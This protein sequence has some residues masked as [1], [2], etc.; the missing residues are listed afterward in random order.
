M[1][2]E[3]KLKSLVNHYREVT[4]L[5]FKTVG[6][7]EVNGQGNSTRD[8]IQNA[9]LKAVENIDKF[10]PEHGSFSDWFS[11]ILRNI[12][13][14]EVRKL[15]NRVASKGDK[16]GEEALFDQRCNLSERDRGL[17]TKAFDN[18][19]ITGA[20]KYIANLYYNLG[21]NSVEIALMTGVHERTVQRFILKFADSVFGTNQRERWER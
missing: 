12:E 10:N 13:V 3:E 9:Y 21:Y 18:P 8:L 19:R 15:E 7:E 20:V 6:M 2:R 1:T 16:L 17:V 11:Y 4:D 5:K 14:D